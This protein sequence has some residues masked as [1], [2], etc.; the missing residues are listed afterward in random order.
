MLVDYFDLEGVVESAGALVNGFVPLVEDAGSRL[1]L[2]PQLD[3]KLAAME[4]A[5]CD[6][7]DPVGVMQFVRF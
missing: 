6:S 2:R 5:G 7:S 1:R 4:E 3:G